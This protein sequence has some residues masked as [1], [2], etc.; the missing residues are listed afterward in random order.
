M[1][2]SV[3]FADDAARPRAPRRAR[4]GAIIAL[5][6]VALAMAAA[7]PLGAQQ[8]V[9]VPRV[10]P[11]AR[12]EVGIARQASV[13]A[14]AGVN[15]PAGTYVRV[16]AALGAGAVWTSGAA[17]ATTRADVTLR[18]L[19]DPFGENRWGPYAGG[20]LTVRRDGWARPAAGVLFV[21]GVEGRRGRRWTPS[22]E[23][24]LG[25]GARLGVVLRRARANGR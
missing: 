23:A 2:A 20:G 18:F 9:V 1:R 6:I 12:V 10:Q 22:V 5:A 19:L 11:E 8:F 17:Q 16:G 21:L 4:C 7:A 3:P 15:V 25:E 24:G 13:L 14:M